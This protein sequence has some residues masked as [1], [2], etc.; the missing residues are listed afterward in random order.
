MLP[1][2]SPAR[3]AGGGIPIAPSATVQGGWLMSQRRAAELEV[4]MPDVFTSDEMPHRV[5]RREA[6][7][8]G[9]G[10][11]I[12]LMTKGLLSLQAQL[13]RL[14]TNLGR[15]H[16]A[17]TARTVVRRGPLQFGKKRH[18]KR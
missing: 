3:P 2:C 13:D 18:L 12:D 17:R 16:Q 6:A 15:L 7:V 9:L 14:A 8:L 10:A 4:D 5:T 1:S 11:N